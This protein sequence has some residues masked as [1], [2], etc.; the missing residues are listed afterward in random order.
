MNIQKIGVF[1]LALLLAGMAMVPMVSATELDK[2]SDEKSAIDA[3]SIDVKTVQLPTLQSERNAVTVEVSDEF[4]SDESIQSSQ[5]S[6]NLKS[7]NILSSSKIPFGAIVK[8]SKNGITTV[9]D[10][11]G[12]I[13]FS[14]DDAKAP[15]IDTPNGLMP[16]TF[17]H[18][19]PDKSVIDDEKNI[20]HVFYQKQRILTIIDENKKSEVKSSAALL[21]S[22]YPAPWIEGAQTSVL[23]NVGHFLARWTVPARPLDYHPYPPSGDV[24]QGSKIT[25]WNGLQKSDGTK[26]LQPVLEWYIKDKSSDPNP[27]SPAWSMATWWA[28]S[29]SPGIHSTRRYIP[30]TG[31]QMQGNMYYYNGYWNGAISDLTQGGSSTLFLTSSQSSALSYQNLQPILGL[32]G[33][34]PQYLPGL[35]SR[36]ICGDV[37]FNSFTI[38]NTN[39]ANVRPS[40]ITGFVNNQY[41]SPF[42]Y[43]LSVNTAS[44][45]T[46]V[47]LNT[48]N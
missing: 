48:E 11:T 38:E 10:S 35:N 22:N 7:S 41:W 39:G 28:V 40:T 9:Y 37:T 26:L 24:T 4:I 34:N 19:V 31:D 44:W 6:E 36:Y 25:I 33:W 16:A 14:A 29:G 20:V 15:K 5:I 13:L 12:K 3:V 17:V 18:E 46:S 23:A 43:G 47:T 27:S 32:E 1:L 21:T 45:P 8:H 30:T 42:T 2:Y